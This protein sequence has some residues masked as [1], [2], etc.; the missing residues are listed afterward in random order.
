MSAG[1]APV[2]F[3]PVAPFG[4]DT[5]PMGIEVVGVPAAAG[6]LTAYNARGITHSAEARKPV[7]I[8]PGF[9]GS[10]EDFRTLVPLL[11]ERRWP[12]VV[13]SQRGQADSAAPLGVHN[14]RLDDF[15]ADAVI[16]ATRVGGGR[17]VHLVGHS[18][19][20]IVA[21]HAALAEPALF[22]SVT[23][24]CSGPYGWP[25]R[26]ADTMR[27]VADRGSIGLWERDHPGRLALSDAE[28]GAESAFLRARARATSRDNLLA[29]AQILR[30]Q[31]DVTDQLRRTGIPLHVAH[32][33]FDDKW[34]IN[35][36]HGM[37]ERLGAS[38]SVIAGGAHSPQLEAADATTAALD[39]FWARLPRPHPSSN[40]H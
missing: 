5:V 16:V 33:E 18:F 3:D 1:S 39:G 20:G 19:G 2:Q 12:V 31:V 7:V 32:G 11:A 13:Y 26:H 25:G 40:D 29:G 23:L 10:K 35:D 30:D 28:L 36:Q 37:A 15:V 17:P 4:G 38:Y 22:R 34:P 6:I 24:L 9:T 14:Y 21:Q 27:I 8:I